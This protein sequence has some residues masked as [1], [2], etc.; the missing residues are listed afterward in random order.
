MSE[1]A[2]LPQL[3]RLAAQL[4][5]AERKQLAE[6]ILQELASAVP[7]EQPPRR[8]AWREIRGSVAYP[9]CAEDAQAWIS[10]GRHEADEQ[11]EQQWNSNK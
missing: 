3:A 10:R 8:R 9:L 1:L 4:P 5:P 6:L 2:T 7:Q 11:R